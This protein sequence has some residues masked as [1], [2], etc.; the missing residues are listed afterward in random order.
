MCIHLPEQNHYLLD[1]TQVDNKQGNKNQFCN[2]CAYQYVMM[3]RGYLSL[4][5][6]LQSLINE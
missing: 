6:I 4:S 5:K 3:F 1:W 2:L